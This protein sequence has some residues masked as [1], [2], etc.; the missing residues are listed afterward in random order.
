MSSL[1]ITL[2]LAAFSTTVL[3]GCGGGSKDDPYAKVYAAPVNP[4]S[5]ADLK[6]YAAKLN[7]ISA[8]VPD[9]NLVF[10]T[11]I[12]M[13]DK[14]TE[15]NSDLIESRKKSKDNLN[16]KG[17]KN[18][19]SI[20][21]LCKIADGK[22]TQS[23]EEFNN[24]EK[25]KIN[26]SQSTRG[27]RCPVL[28][29]DTNDL[30][31]TANGLNSSVRNVDFSITLLRSLKVQSKSI[32]SDSG[33]LGY[34][35]SASL[36]GLTNADSSSNLTGP[37]SANVNATVSLELASGEVIK[38]S[39]E[40]VLIGNLSSSSDTY[41]F[42]GYLVADLQTAKGNLRIGMITNSGNTQLYVNGKKMEKGS[43]LSRATNDAL[44]HG[45]QMA[46]EQNLL[47]MFR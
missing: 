21:D 1:K 36:K 32:Q 2:A 31:V 23:T 10:Q 26:L 39:V 7:P 41:T 37:V 34:T 4:I 8:N 11:T 22:K 18:L 25:Q 35:F 38:G 28:I 16:A 12:G 40:G 27:E 29:N 45:L 30:E 46:S 14:L 15:E 3:M 20:Q 44:N 19:Q 47:D 24:G 43:T 6:S 17:R 33:L 9:R 5:E 13:S 42:D